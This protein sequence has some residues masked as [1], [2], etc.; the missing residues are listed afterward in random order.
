MSSTEQVREGQTS[1]QEQQQ[2]LGE[3]TVPQIRE[4]RALSFARQVNA[5]A[6]EVSLNQKRIVELANLWRDTT[7]AIPEWNWPTYLQTDDINERAA[8]D[9]VLHSQNACYWHPGL[10]AEGNEVR[11]H[12]GGRE[13][14]ADLAAL[15]IQRSWRIISQPGFLANVSESFVENELFDARVRIPLIPQRTA[16]LR[17]VGRFLDDMREHGQSFIQLFESL[18]NDAYL[19]AEFLQEKLPLW[20]DPFMKRAQLFPAMLYGRFQNNPECPISKASLVNLTE[21]LDYRIPETLYAIGAINYSPSLREKI[22]NRVILESDSREETEIRA[23]SLVALKTL[24][25][26][27]NEMR[28]PESQITA[29]ETDFLC[30][31]ALRTKDEAM[32]QKLIARE[33][34]PHPR[35]LTMRY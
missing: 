22:C 18:H 12:D 2:D 30:W 35:C 32:L 5:Y 28:G 14:G 6:E 13:Y 21:F 31:G 20:E 24:R 11:F 8:Y 33:R 17:E 4:N 1:R 34:L 9:L 26:S 15:K 25:D 3:A 29:L 7:F 23:V 16:C 27:L 10:D 19:I